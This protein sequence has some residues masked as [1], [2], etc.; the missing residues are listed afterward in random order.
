MDSLSNWLAHSQKKY[1]EICGHKY[2]FTKGIYAL[3]GSSS[4]LTH[5][6]YPE[7]LPDFIPT[8][9]YVRQASLWIFRMGCYA[10]R[11]WWATTAWL[12]L[13][14]TFNIITLRSLVWLADQL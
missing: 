9:V 8:V 4:K 10:A 1:C 6:V 7:H 3:N 14:P 13:L 11:F 5:A 12:I 2:T